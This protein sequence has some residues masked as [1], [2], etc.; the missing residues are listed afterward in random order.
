MLS[1]QSDRANEVLSHVPS[2]GSFCEGWK[3]LPHEGNGRFQLGNRRMACFG[4]G[5]C[6][7]GTMVQGPRSATLNGI[8]ALGLDALPVP[9]ETSHGGQGHT[10]L[11]TTRICL[12]GRA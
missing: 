3:D 12:C 8:G 4:Q 7:G 11:L 6:T 2:C 5:P 1:T 9:I 10:L